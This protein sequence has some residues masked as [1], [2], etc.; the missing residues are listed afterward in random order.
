MAYQAQPP[1]VSSIRTTVDNIGTGGVADTVS[2]FAQSVYV[3]DAPTISGN[4]HQL[5]V[6][7]KAIEAALKVVHPGAIIT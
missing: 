2:T 6:R 5:A 4:F 7:V 1:G 3:T